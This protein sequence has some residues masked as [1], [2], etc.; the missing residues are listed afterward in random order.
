MTEKDK[1][2]KDISLTCYIPLEVVKKIVDS[3]FEFVANVIKS[4]DRDDPSTF[5][6]VNVQYLGKFAVKESKK[7]FYNKPKDD[8]TKDSDE[9]L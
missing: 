1:I 3:Q 5:K 8:R 2:L 7:E 6:N 9:H 4:C